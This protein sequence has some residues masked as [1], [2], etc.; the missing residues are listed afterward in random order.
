[1]SLRVHSYVKRLDFSDLDFLELPL[2]LL[3]THHAGRVPLTLM[4]VLDDQAYNTVSGCNLWIFG[5]NLCDNST[6]VP[7]HCCCTFSANRHTFFPKQMFFFHES[8]I[9]SLVALPSRSFE[10]KKSSIIVPSHKYVTYT[11]NCAVLLT[12]MHS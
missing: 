1:M 4:Q 5:F 12:S 2:L 9:P 11:S 8:G 6:P 10:N 3:P 7:S